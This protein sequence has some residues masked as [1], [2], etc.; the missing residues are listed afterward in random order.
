MINGDKEVGPN[1]VLAFKREG[2]SNKDFSLKDF[3][4]S[5]TYKGLLSFGLKN[6][7]FALNELK[8]LIQKKDFIRKAKKLIPD[9]ESEMFEKGNSGVR[10]Q[11]VQNNG[12]LLMD[13]KIVNHENQVHVL[14]APSPGATASL[15]IADYILDNYTK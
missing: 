5:V 7:S 6:F 11:A 12:N 14:N 3:Y 10:A 4:D 9:V 1:A 13:F 8:A 2:Y 15:A